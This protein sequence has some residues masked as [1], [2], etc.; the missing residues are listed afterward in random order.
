MRQ[1][2]ALNAPF[3]WAEI[4][5]HWECIS[6]SI[7]VPRNDEAADLKPVTTL[8]WQHVE[9]NWF[10][11]RKYLLCITLDKLMGALELYPSFICLKLW[12]NCYNNVNEC[13][14]RD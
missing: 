2:S 8:H 11:Y 9:E 5:L 3:F 14:I 4:E 7:T 6:T 10:D 1:F 13:G 12:L